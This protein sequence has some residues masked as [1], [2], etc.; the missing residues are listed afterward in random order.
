MVEGND[1]RHEECIDL[2]LHAQVLKAG[3]T[4]SFVAGVKK[5][6]KEKIYISI[7]SKFIHR[8]L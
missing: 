2:K 7:A 4:Y 6:E 1:S 3:V 5:F 8:L